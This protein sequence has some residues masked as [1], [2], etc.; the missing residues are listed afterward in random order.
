[1]DDNSALLLF[2]SC[3]RLILKNLLVGGMGTYEACPSHFEH[4]QRCIVLKSFYTMLLNE[5]TKH[6]YPNKSSVV[7]VMLHMF[8]DEAKCVC[9]NFQ[10]TY[11]IFI[12]KPLSLDIIE[13]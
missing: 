12:L 4:I 3:T 11:E 9:L 8:C 7:M 2:A 5:V 6:V 13:K 1:M 10:G